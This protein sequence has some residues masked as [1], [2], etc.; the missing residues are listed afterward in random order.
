MPEAEA[1]EAAGAGAVEAAA[2]VEAAEA[3]GGPAVAVS[4]EA[5]VAVVPG[6]AEG[7]S[8]DQGEAVSPDHLPLPEVLIVPV[9]SVLAP[10]VPQVSNEEMAVE[11]LPETRFHAIGLPGNAWLTARLNYRR[12]GGST[13]PTSI[14]PRPGPGLGKVLPIGRVPG[15]G[16]GSPIGRVPGLGKGLPIGRATGTSAIS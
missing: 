12:R 4:P 15:L 11:F 10:G 14:G 5:A 16:K 8:P 7:T 3:E 13:V 6:Q 2:V 1:V 9:W